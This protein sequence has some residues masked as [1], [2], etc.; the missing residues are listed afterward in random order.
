M[1]LACSVVF[2]REAC[3]EQDVGAGITDNVE[4]QEFW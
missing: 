2:S 3:T 4:E 1:V